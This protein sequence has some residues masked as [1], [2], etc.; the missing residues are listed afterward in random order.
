MSLGVICVTELRLPIERVWN[1]DSVINTPSLSCVSMLIHTHV[2]SMCVLSYN[3]YTSHILCLAASPSRWTGS[4][5][6]LFGSGRCG[7]SGML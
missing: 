4:E 5:A 2:Y 7:Y 6:A 3:I 1:A